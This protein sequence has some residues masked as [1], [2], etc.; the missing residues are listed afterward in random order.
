MGTL[1]DEALRLALEK[2]KKAPAESRTVAVQTLM[3][4]ARNIFANP[5]EVK[6]RHIK[7]TNTAL[8]NRILSV[9]GGE[10]VLRAWGWVCEEGEWVLPHTSTPHCANVVY[11][12]VEELILSP[13]QLAHKHAV[14]KR[15]QEQAEAE[16]KERAERERIRQQLLA[17]RRE[18]NQNVARASHAVGPSANAGTHRFQPPPGG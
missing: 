17:D 2:L 7:A 13:E 15:R 10:D 9:P 1:N 11:S 5:G 8:N 6:Y 14:E 4:Y 16:R 3:A 12:A 18:T